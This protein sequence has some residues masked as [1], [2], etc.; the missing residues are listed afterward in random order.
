MTRGG[1]GFSDRNDFFDESPE[2]E[3]PCHRY[4]RDLFVSAGLWSL[5]ALGVGLIISAAIMIL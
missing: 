3:W 5:V 1:T 2:L 4:D